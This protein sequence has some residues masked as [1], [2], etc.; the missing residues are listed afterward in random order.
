MQMC[1]GY[2]GTLLSSYGGGDLASQDL[3]AC[4]MNV[5]RQSLEARRDFAFI[6]GQV[7][8]VKSKQGLQCSGVGRRAVQAVP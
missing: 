3:R 8:T 6:A 7:S 2:D 1:G 5:T 4:F